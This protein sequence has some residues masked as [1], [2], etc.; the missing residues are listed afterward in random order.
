MYL[1]TKVKFV[2]QRFQRL[3]H[4]RQTNPQMQLK[5]LHLLVVTICI[6]YSYVVNKHRL[7][8]TYN[9][10]IAGVNLCDKS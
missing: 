9:I 5:T 3:E 1:C 10:S 6:L 4:Y 7:K 2:G 8:V